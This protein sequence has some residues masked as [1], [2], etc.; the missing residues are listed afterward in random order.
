VLFSFGTPFWQPVPLKVKLTL[1]TMHVVAAIITVGL[2]TTRA[3][4]Q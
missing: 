1:A 3:R 4:E 2:L